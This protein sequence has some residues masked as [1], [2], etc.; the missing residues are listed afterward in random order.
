[1]K[2]KILIVLQSLPYPLNTGGR[3]G[4][5]SCIEAIKDDLDVTITCYNDPNANEAIAKLKQLWLNVEF[6]PYNIQKREWSKYSLIKKALNKLMSRF[7]K[8]NIQYVTDNLIEERFNHYHID[9]YV[10]INNLIEKKKIDIVQCEFLGNLSL[11]YSL[12]DNVK[13]VFVH[14]EIGFIKEE[15][16]FGVMNYSGVFANYVLNMMRCNEID[17]LSRYDAVVT[18]STI[19]TKKL[20]NAGVI[21]NIYSS[22]S[23]VNLVDDKISIAD[24]SKRLTFIGP[25]NHLPNK[26]G[27]YWFLNEI[28]GKLN[29]IDKG[30]KLDIIG[31]WSNETKKHIEASYEGVTCMGFV[32]DLKNALIGSIMIVPIRIGSGIRMKLL[33]AS[34]LGIPFVSTT[35]GA[36]GLP[37]ID[38]KDCLLADSPADFINSII[39]MKSVELQQQLSESAYHTIKKHF[40]KEELKKSRLIVYKELFDEYE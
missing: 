7:A 15:Q 19:D 4:V 11:V 1:M 34:N 17:T 28:W 23:M 38:K 31:K 39:A 18:H 13:K 3:Q 16:R 26:D 40:N 5:Y 25:E 14:H 12:P 8:N 27:I 2:R 9:Y 36:E 35:I 30:W 21:T 22:F 29:E 37:F 33:E 20:K 6:I 10:F 24:T 32:D